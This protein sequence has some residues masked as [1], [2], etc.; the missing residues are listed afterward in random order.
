VLKVISGEGVTVGPILMGAAS[1][2]HVM[3]PSS[4][5]RRVMNMT[6]LSVAQARRG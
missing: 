6:A 2:A 1:P 5:V 3:T 4:T